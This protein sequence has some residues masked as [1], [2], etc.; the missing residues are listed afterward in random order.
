MIYLIEYKRNN[1]LLN[2]IRFN[3]NYSVDDY[4]N[5][6]KRMEILI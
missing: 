4:N 2:N 5:M 1:E 6:F 3:N